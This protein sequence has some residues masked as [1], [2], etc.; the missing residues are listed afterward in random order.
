MFLVLFLLTVCHISEEWGWV[1]CSGTLVCSDALVLS[2]SLWDS[3]MVLSMW[4]WVRI[5]GNCGEWD[6][7]TDPWF[8]DVR[9]Y[10]RDVEGFK[11]GGN[12]TLYVA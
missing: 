7:D 5:D 1:G 6:E 3:L 12:S 2:L 11:Y 4:F 8:V 10:R 9:G